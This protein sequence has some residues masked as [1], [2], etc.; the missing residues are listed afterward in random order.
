MCRMKLYILIRESRDEK[1]NNLNQESLGNN[2]MNQLNASFESYDNL[3]DKLNRLIEL[4]EHL[5]NSQSL[6]MSSAMEADAIIPEKQIL[7]TYF[8]TNP[9]EQ[10]Y[11]LAVESIKDSIV[12][13][14]TKAYN[15][16]VEMLKKFI[17]WIKSFF[18]SN[19][20]QADEKQVNQIKKEL[21]DQ[22]FL[23]CTKD[24]D[25]LLAEAGTAALE[26]IGI[27]G[28]GDHEYRG[29]P[30][31]VGDVFEIFKR[32]LNEHEVDFLTS[33]HQYKIIKNVVDEFSHGHYPDFIN[34]I[35]DEI[36]S[37]LQNGLTEAPHV[38]RD[39]DVVERFSHKQKR[40][41]DQIKQKYHTASSGI[42]EMERMCVT[43]PPKGDHQHLNLFQKKPSILFPH[44]ERIWDTVKFEKI[45]DEDK[46]L[47]TSLEKVRK[48]F[49]TDSKNISS[50]LSSQKQ[51]W[52]PEEAILRL[53][54]RTNR[55]MLQH[56]SSLV[57]VG[58][59]IK[60]SANTAYQATMK[61]FSYITRL[62]NAISK[63][64]N[65]NREKLNKCIDV[66][67][68][69]RRAIDKITAIA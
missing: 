35:S 56:I 59:F 30:I 66:I 13:T 5:G 60:N 1:R 42:E 19:K 65:V 14:V 12:E 47:I 37:W 7:S 58:V 31:K 69:K 49:E 62:L 38:G 52:P 18:T 11:Q 22:K 15:A 28:D 64:P 10:K 20:F 25:D 67:Q 26:D 50:K 63:L 2:N 61:S 29:D 4:G 45:T 9:K 8:G 16:I 54:Q 36:Q 32:S 3:G 27:R 46:K 41:L 33:G 34:G 51:T 6:I 23:T 57:K 24:V 21:S 17:G 43:N 55:E 40:I 48:Q 68:A 39:E 44:I 53:A